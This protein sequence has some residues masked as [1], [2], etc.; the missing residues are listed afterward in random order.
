MTGS[1]ARCVRS[2]SI[3]ATLDQLANDVVRSCARMDAC[4]RR[5][6]DQAQLDRTGVARSLQRTSFRRQGLGEDA[7]AFDR[8]PPELTRSKRSLLRLR[9]GIGR[10]GRRARRLPRSCAEPERDIVAIGAGC[11][12]DRASPRR[13]NSL[14]SSA[15]MD[16]PG[17]SA[18]GVPPQTS[19]DW[20]WR[21]N[22]SARQTR[23]ALDRRPSTRRARYICPSPRRLR[24]SA[25]V[26]RTCGSS[27]STS[28]SV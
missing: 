3:P 18:A 15:A 20:R 28:V 7:F 11:D 8:L 23:S 27:R 22:R 9:H 21:V 1:I 14:A 6:L 2:I 24:Y 12:D 5:T 13:T 19:W 4:A 25:S 17:A 26:E 16:S 10:T